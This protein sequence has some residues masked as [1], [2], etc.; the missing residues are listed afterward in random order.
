MPAPK[1]GLGGSVRRRA[2]QVS[3][4]PFRAPSHVISGRAARCRVRSH[5]WMRGQLREDC[6]ARSVPRRRAGALHFGRRPLINEQKKKLR[7]GG[8]RGNGTAGDKAARVRTSTAMMSSAASSL[9]GLG[10]ALSL[11]R[12][13]PT[14]EGEEAVKSRSLCC[15]L[16]IIQ[17]QGWSRRPCEESGLRW[18]Y[19]PPSWRRGAGVEGR[20]S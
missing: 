2:F 18:L 16:C 12:P 11:T 14:G 3:P 7:R 9:N 8:P 10:I 15:D 5:S 17:A 13:L 20:S 19:F 1:R 4:A 6:R